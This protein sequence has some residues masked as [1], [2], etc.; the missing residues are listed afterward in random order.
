MSSPNPEERSIPVAEVT[1]AVEAAFLQIRQ[2][3]V[4][5]EALAVGHQVVYRT[6]GGE[7]HTGPLVIRSV[8]ARTALIEGFLNGRTDPVQLRVMLT[9]LAPAEMVRDIVHR[10]LSEAYPC[11]H[12][13]GK[14]PNRPAGTQPRTI[15]QDN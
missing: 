13:Q 4:A 15:R 8:D 7:V 3:P 6:P 1:L 11:P 10:M 12:C 9:E 2:Y 5:R 14:D